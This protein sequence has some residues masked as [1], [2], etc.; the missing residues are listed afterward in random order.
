MRLIKILFIAA[1]AN[2]TQSCLPADEG[3]VAVLP[4]TGDVVDPV[5]GGAREQNQVWIDLTAPD[6]P[7]QNLRT[8]WDL[9]FYTGDEY[10]VVINGSIAMAVGKIPNAND[11][12]AVKSSDL[13]SLM[14]LVQLGTFDVSNLQY[15]DN[16]NGMFLT[17]T[18]GIAPVSEKESDN[19]IYLV[20]MGRK[21]AD[22]NSVIAPGSALLAGDTRG[23]KK[24]QIIR[25]GTT[26]YKI[27]F[28]DLNAT[29]HQE[30]IITKNPD[31]NF[32]FFSL[33]NAKEVM[34][35][36]RKKNWDIAFTT[37]TNEVF[38]GTESAGSYFYADYVITNITDGVGAYQVNV[39]AGQNMDQFYANYKMK[40][41]DAVKFI[42]NDQRAIGSNWRVTAV[43]GGSSPHIQGNV[44]FII[45]DAEGFMF[46]LRFNKMSDDKTGE[47]GHPQFEY[48]PL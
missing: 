23:W 44:F 37:F 43:P 10:R 33:E 29:Q 15:V 32:N 34:I 8:D 26:G 36:P 47:R 19:P 25:N 17:Q 45:K 16:P 6:N 41:V 14:D 28:A 46:K 42:F 22:A 40:D 20:N 38:S 3:P 48:E 21:L 1:L 4:I 35:Q 7:S 18:T 39:P 30:Y 2:I 5:V 27:K 12:D 11:I 31:Y 24:M 13:T 9:G